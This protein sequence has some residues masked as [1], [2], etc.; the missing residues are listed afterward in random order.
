MQL[1]GS[2]AVNH[3]QPTAAALIVELDVH[4]AVVVFVGIRVEQNAIHHAED[5]GGRADT[6]HQGENR[7]DYKARR[8]AKL[9][10]GE[11]QVLHEVP[12]EA[13]SLTEDTDL[14]EICFPRIDAVEKIRVFAEGTC[15][16]SEHLSEF[17]HRTGY[18]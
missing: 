15:A 2:A 11:P 16:D 17:E 10:E 8:F 1:L 7:G 13:F 5:G 4:H 3:Q 12:H 14:D 9:P 6:Q 18:S